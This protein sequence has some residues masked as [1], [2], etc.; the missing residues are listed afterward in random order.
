VGHAYRTIDKLHAAKAPGSHE[1]RD[2]NI[3]NTSAS[4]FKGDDSK[5][6]K[7][8]GSEEVDTKGAHPTVRTFT[9]LAL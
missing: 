2:W 6:F 9:H 8:G 5:A 3:V 4:H 7:A 1:V